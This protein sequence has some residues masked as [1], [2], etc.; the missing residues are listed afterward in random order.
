MPASMARQPL[1]EI[2][3]ACVATDLTLSL[4]LRVR[5]A[6]VLG[7]SCEAIDRVLLHRDRGLPVLGVF[8][9]VQG[10]YWEL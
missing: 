10:E 2:L 5:S 8:L 3:R 6:D 7:R 1:H 9:F 4:H